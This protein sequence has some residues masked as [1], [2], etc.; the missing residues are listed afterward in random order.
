MET[1][2]Q[3]DRPLVGAAQIAKE[4]SEIFSREVTEGEV[5]YYVKAGKLKS[6]TK[7]GASLISSPRKLRNETRSII[8]G[9][10]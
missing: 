4:L 6:I 9:A 2:N 8:G 10:I 1:I 5:Y 3:Q 7:W